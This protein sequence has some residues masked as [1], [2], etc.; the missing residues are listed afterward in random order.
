MSTCNTA[1]VFCFLWGANE[2]EFTAA[3]FMLVGIFFSVYKINAVY[4]L[5]VKIEASI[6]FFLLPAPTSNLILQ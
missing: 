6:N 4:K 5:Y 2:T 1:T 3:V